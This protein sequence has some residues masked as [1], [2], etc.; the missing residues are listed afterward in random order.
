MAIN[1]EQIGPS[2]IVEV[3]ASRAPA[4]IRDCDLSDAG[5][6]S[7]IGKGHVAIVAMERIT[8]VLEI[9]NVDR[10]A[11]GVIEV[12]DGDS[13]S[14]H[15]TAITAD[16]GAGNIADIGK[17]PFAIVPIE[18][19]RS[20][21]VGDKNVGPPVVVEIAPHHAEPVV[22]GG[23]VDASGFR[24]IG[25]RAVSIVAIEAVAQ[26]LH[27]AWATLHRDTAKSAS[28]ADSKLR[29]MIKIELHVAGD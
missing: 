14:C 1:H 23:I 20:G 5:R 13:H 22:P 19:V 11:S 10:K 6:I 27:A 28:G 17:V 3:D 16:R 9:R 26:S 12:A 4:H 25:E 7:G 21:I 15:L 2:V 8:L 24:N 29:K 18:V